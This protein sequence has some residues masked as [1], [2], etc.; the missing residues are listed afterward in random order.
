MQRLLLLPWYSMVFPHSHRCQEHLIHIGNLLIFPCQLE[1]SGHER[2]T[3]TFS[4]NV[5]LCREQIQQGFADIFQSLEYRIPSK[6]QWEETSWPSWGDH[7]GFYRQD[8]RWMGLVLLG[9]EVVASGGAGSSAFTSANAQGWEK[10]EG[11]GINQGERFWKGQ[12]GPL[13]TSATLIAIKHPAIICRKE[14]NFAQ[15]RSLIPLAAA[16]ECLP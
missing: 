14:L 10:R 12:E 13:K 5:L 6:N 7:E 1:N 8:L 11:F 3:R 16:S 4:I 15:R 9:S 2:L